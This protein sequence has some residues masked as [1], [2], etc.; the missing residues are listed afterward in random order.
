[1]RLETG[2]DPSFWGITK[3]WRGKADH[4]Q[5]DWMGADREIRSVRHSPRPKTW[6]VPTEGIAWG[7]GK[8]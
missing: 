2:R 5:S 7:S 1:M 4:I 6:A 8:G 3:L